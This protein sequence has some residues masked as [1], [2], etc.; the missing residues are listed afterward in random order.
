VLSWYVWYP[1]AQLAYPAGL[2]NIAICGIVATVVDESLG[3]YWSGNLGDYMVIQ[4][5]TLVFSLIA[6]YLLAITVERPLF[7]LSKRVKF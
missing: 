1:I 4:F 5:I 7:N 3:S 2:L 6:G